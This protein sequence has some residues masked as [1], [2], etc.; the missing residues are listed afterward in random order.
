MAKAF[1]SVDSG[2]R[3]GE[4]YGEI[5]VPLEE[6]K[7]AE[8]P[9]EAR[10]LH[11]F[12]FLCRRVYQQF[13]E[14]GRGAK[15]QEQYADAVSFLN[16]DL[17]AAEFNAAIKAALISSMAFAL[18]ISTL[19]F[20]SPIQQAVTLGLTGNVNITFLYIFSP[21]II[22]SL[23]LT[24]F[25]QNFPLNAAKDEQTKALTYVPEIVGYMIMSMKLVPNLE[26]AVE[27]AAENGKGK[28]AEDFKKII[29]EAQIGVYNTLS[30]A[31][32]ELAYKW[33]KFSS[34][35]KEALM[36]IRASVLENTEA[37][38]FA[39][40]DR[41]MDNTLLSI[42]EK[43]EHYARELNQ[44]SIILFYLGVLLPLILIIILPVGSAF[45]GQGLAR[46]EIMIGLYNLIIPGIAFAFAYTIIRRRPPTYKAPVIPDNHPDLPGKNLMEFRG[47]TA[48]TRY[49]VGGVFALGL[50]LSLFLSFQGFPPKLLGLQDEFGNPAPQMI[51]ADAD[52]RE[53]IIR[54]GFRE[55]YFTDNGVL[56]QNFIRA[57]F[58][59]DEVQ[60]RVAF[61]RT[62]FFMKPQNDISPNNLVYGI[63]ITI[64]I[65]VYIFLY[66]ASIYKRKIQLKIVQ[67]ESEFK[68][69]LYVL[70]SRM[71]EN[72]P[73]EEALK[74]AKNF[75]PGMLISQKI[76]GKTLDN[77]TL[78]GL[79]LE[80]AIFDSNYG[81]LRDIPSTLIRG[82]MTLLVSSVQLGVDVAARTLISLSVQL[83]NAEKVTKML[84]VLISDITSMMT[85]MAVF[86]A[87]VV[88]GITTSLQRVVM[89]TLAQISTSGLTETISVTDISVR[90]A[91]VSLPTGGLEE[92]GKAFIIQPETLIS[93]AT[94]PQF[95][96]I[97]A[98]YVVELV[99]IMTYFTTMIEEDNIL[100]TKINIARALPIA[101]IVF[102][103]SSYMSNLIIG[104]FFG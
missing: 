78:L 42:R 77:I 16:W 43:M 51:P 101:L 91:G 13:P 85:S 60:R 103:A 48:D 55:D 37:K 36:M 7:K 1:R 84:S 72:K 53:V 6:F 74:H 64:A 99:L 27:F 17:S 65:C 30:E 50:L 15:F 22:F 20:F 49:V 95:L 32:D 8:S 57:G 70:A 14:L 19:L 23:G 67:M 21:F 63:I 75:L 79:P 92:V 45:T 40:L 73:V 38:R 59:E 10:K 94:P 12:V 41:T 2:S 56:A 58:P 52:P 28:I 33:G 26:K 88:L 61:E 86:I 89:L 31:L 34:E 39:L 3:M 98:I 93:L 24:Y 5:K 25:V 87:P 9:L 83:N 46:P 71:G 11:P 90:G 82:S 35:F 29:W 66:Y 68:D 97:I 100:K 69:A 81:S 104:N 76:F 54:A 44:P 80:Q 62:K 96:I 47:F 102:L 18:I 4:R